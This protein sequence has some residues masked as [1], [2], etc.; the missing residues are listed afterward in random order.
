VTEPKTD[1]QGEDP[2]MILIERLRNSARL[3]TSSDALNPVKLPIEKNLYWKAAE[4]IAS[5][6]GGVER[7]TAENAKLLADAFDKRSRYNL[8]AARVSELQAALKPFAMA[9]DTLAYESIL[10][11]AFGDAT[12]VTTADLR[13]ARAALSQHPG[14]GEKA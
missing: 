4:A 1:C 12:S 9:G 6:Q 8:A 2:V 14:E 7:L 13:R 10:T 5:L 3:S 11:T